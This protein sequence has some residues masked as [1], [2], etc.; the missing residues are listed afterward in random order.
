M[1]LILLL[2]TGWPYFIGLALIALFTACPVLKR[3][4]FR[5]FQRILVLLGV[6]LIAVSATPAP[7]WIQ[8]LG[9]L[10]I[11]AWLVTAGSRAPRTRPLRQFLR[12]TAPTLAAV[13]AAIE[14][15][16]FLL[17]QL[18][19][20]AHTRLVTLGDSLT[21]DMG[22]GIEPWPT[23][24]ARHGS[25]SLTNLARPGAATSE[26]LPQADQIPPDDAIVLVALGG[27][28]VLRGRPVEDFE[29]DLEYI[30]AAAARNGRAV[31]MLEI[32]LP[33]GCNRYGEVQRRLATRHGVWLVPKRY[34][35]TLFADEQT[36]VDGLHLSN[37]GHAALAGIVWN[38]IAPA[39][40]KTV[41]SADPRP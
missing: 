26:A 14:V 20:G 41:P 33:P 9:G 32:P 37:P 36:T 40:A 22:G 30:L 15:P 12:F 13:A 18:P 16:H 23:I 5:A 28:D 21:A 39:C 8:I 3:P 27:H 10:A 1:K 25:L 2:T 29:R 35:A 4:L 34:L 7:I 17:P 38:C 31:L 6:L 19:P 11:A 24:L